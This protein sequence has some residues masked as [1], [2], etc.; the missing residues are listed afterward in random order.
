MRRNGCYSFIYM[1]KLNRIKRSLFFNA[2]LIVTVA[3][4][5]DIDTLLQNLN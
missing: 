3:F 1:F 2:S 5:F 4:K